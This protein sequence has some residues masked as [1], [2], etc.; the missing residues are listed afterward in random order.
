MFASE[1]A[2]LLDSIPSLFFLNLVHIGVVN[3]Q[4]LNRQRLWQQEVPYVVA[5]DRQMIQTDCLTTF[6]RQFYSLQ[7]RVHTHINTYTREIGVTCLKWVGSR[8]YAYL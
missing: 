5:S 6:H 3:Q 7:M 1:R 8:G 4:G 2:T